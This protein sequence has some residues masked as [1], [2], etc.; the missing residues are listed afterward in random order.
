MATRPFRV[1]CWLMLVFTLIG[2]GA[3]IVQAT[4]GGQDGAASPVPDRIAFWLG[5]VIPQ[6]TYAFAQTLPAGRGVVPLWGV[7]ARNDGWLIVLVASQIVS[8]VPVVLAAGS[9]PASMLPHVA[10]AF[11]SAMFIAA[12]AWQLRAGGDAHRA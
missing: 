10:A 1:A 11:V 4:R 2:I 5:V 12:R 6:L 3:R 8:V 7:G 9:R